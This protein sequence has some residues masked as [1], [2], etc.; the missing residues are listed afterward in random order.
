MAYL[1]DTNVLSEFLKKSPNEGVIR[2]FDK[3]H[4]EQQQISSFSIAEIQKGLSKLPPSSRRAELVNWF[5]KV[6]DRYEDRILSFGL[7]TARIWGDLTA[8]LE[9]RGLILP[10]IDSLIAATALE[11]DLTLVTRNEGDFEDCGVRVLNIWE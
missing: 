11:H 2:W 1:L 9:K 8:D 6:I 10:V 5:E 7:E 3:S 4:E